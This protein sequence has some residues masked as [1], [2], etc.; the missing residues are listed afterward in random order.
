MKIEPLWDR[1]G[2][3]APIGQQLVGAPS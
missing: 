1:A 3:D 2:E